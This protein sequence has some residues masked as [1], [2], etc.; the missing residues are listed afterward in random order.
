MTNCITIAQESIKKIVILLFW[1]RNVVGAENI[2]LENL[3][4]L[5]TFVLIC[6]TFG[7]SVFF[8]NL[9]SRF[10][11]I[12]SISERCGKFLET[13]IKQRSICT[14]FIVPLYSDY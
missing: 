13:L 12:L 11:R 10:F 5:Y 2:A 14:H 4:I 3:P 8:R 9:Q 1:S 6:T 7:S